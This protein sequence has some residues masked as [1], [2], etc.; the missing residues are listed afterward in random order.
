MIS[1][2]SGFCFLLVL[3]GLFCMTA[4]MAVGYDASLP[5]VEKG[6]LDL[7]NWR[8]D[9]RG[10][11][12]L[13]GDWIF[14]WQRLYQPQE[15]LGDGA[16]QSTGFQKVPGIWNKREVDG[17]PI[18]GEGYATYRL[19]VL[20]NP[21]CC[22]LVPG[23]PLSI[24][25]HDSHSFH[26]LGIRFL[27]VET[28]FSVYVN[29]KKI[30]SAGTVGVSPQ[31]S[32][33]RYS[34]HT[35]G[36]LV[37]ENALDI[38]IHVSNFHH[39]K[40]GLESVIL[41]GCEKEVRESRQQSLYRDIFL[42]SSIIIM[43]FFY[44][45]IFLLWKKERGPLYFSTIC[46]VMAIRSVVVGDYFI[47]TVFPGIPWEWLMKIEYLAFLWPVMFFNLFLLALFP[48]EI[49]RS[50]VRLYTAVIIGLS[51]LILL[52]PVKTF[53]TL[54]FPNQVIVISGGAY[55]LFVL[56]L[57]MKRRRRGSF[58]LFLGGIALFLTGVNDILY[59]N[60]ILKTG[61]LLPVGMFILILF[62][63]LV[64][65]QRSSVAFFAVEELSSNLEKQVSERTRQLLLKNN[66]FKEL[67]HI[68]CH[69]LQNP[70]ANIQNI[71][72][73]SR[74]DP[75]MFTEMA[76]F[77]ASAVDNGLAIIEMVRGIRVLE[78]KRLSMALEPLSLL[79]LV[80]ASEQMLSQQIKRKSISI[81]N[82]I[83]AKI[84][85]LA[86]R[87]SFINSVFSNILTNA[88]KFSYPESVIKVEGYQKEGVVTL[89]VFDSGI[90]MS[91]QL[92]NNLF[93]MDKSTSRL[94][95]EGETGTG[96]GMPLVNTIIEVYGG[97]I[98]VFSK[99]KANGGDH[100]TEVRLTLKS[101]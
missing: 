20:L 91:Q 57:A 25:N 43:G 40:G 80:M 62:Q 2:R 11:V 34:P 53:S 55:L 69:D 64:L 77:A 98:E 85:V 7:R 92:L 44:T 52:T 47:L 35:A 9:E 16:P 37:E 45:G 65:A 75:E 89:S 32:K 8:L 99:E 54:L 33:P 74:E 41:L 1:Q 97:R 15:L 13:D 82:Q 71:I 14:Y 86:E 76:P 72:G 59:N 18:S 81:E 56:A 61:M 19:K 4:G 21:D 26:A 50:A 78:E 83:D 12:R 68:L 95:T 36:F 23:S 70:L 60:L 29:G 10:P 46:F 31:N 39:R 73:L 28:A 58:L 63:A 79:E 90:G 27:F 42:F 66:Q 101:P 38:V 3:I 51:L 30:T 67:L 84:Q 48:L 24:K 94:G 5:K 100:G 96:F 17:Q 93:D 22:S 49:N 6:I 88:I 87:T